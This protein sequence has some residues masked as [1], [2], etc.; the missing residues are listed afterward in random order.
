[1]LETIS[2]ELPLYIVENRAIESCPQKSRVPIMVSDF[3]TREGLQIADT[4]VDYIL[5]KMLIITQNNLWRYSVI[6]YQYEFKYSGFIYIYDAYINTF[7]MSFMHHCNFVV[8]CTFASSIKNERI[9]SAFHIPFYG[10]YSL[11][12]Y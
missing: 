2:C 6:K 7:K 9:L 5:G 12:R 4:C 3:R 10:L 1:M 11:W 8:K